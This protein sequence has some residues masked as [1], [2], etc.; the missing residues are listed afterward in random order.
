MLNKVW[1]KSK[2]LY[3]NIIALLLIIVQA[4]TGFIFPLEYQATILA[5]LNALNRMLLTNSNIT[6]K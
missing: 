1:W 5:I 2:T 6:L 3:I 4:N